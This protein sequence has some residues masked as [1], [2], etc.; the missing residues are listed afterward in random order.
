MMVSIRF[1]GRGG[2]GAVTASKI[3]A[4]VSYL[5]GFMSQSM[6]FFG[7]ERRGAPVIAFT[8]ISDESLFETSQVYHPNIVVVLDPVI[9]KA[10]DIF[11][12]V[13][14][15]GVIVVNT[16]K[17]PEDFEFEQEY[18]HIITVDATG[19][20]IKNNLLLAGIPVVNTPMLG[21]LVRAFEI[22]NIPIKLD[23]LEQVVLKKFGRAGE[24][25]AKAVRSAYEETSYKLIK[26]IKKHKRVK[27]EKIVVEVPISKP[28]EGVAGKTK[29][30]RDFRPDIDYEK[31]NS[32]LSCWLHCP[33][34][35]IRVND[36]VEIDYEYCKGCL[37]CSAVCP[38]KAIKTDREVF[39]DA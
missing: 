7:A 34:S 2:Q 23:T 26:G 20:A 35:A 9:L 15:G 30:W 33:E 3:L 8:R 4:E 12:G 21:A 10:V 31:C 18:L 19:I 5:S 29:F 24:K 28:S 22:L 14:E 38:K 1:H 6:P 32:C 13:K 27:K 25:N 39:A 36:R 16:T 11:A 17:K 37:V